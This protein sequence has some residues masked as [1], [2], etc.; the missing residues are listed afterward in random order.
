VVN[1]YKFRIFSALLIFYFTGIKIS[2]AGNIQDRISFKT[3]YSFSI[4][5]A[6][7][8]PFSETRRWYDRSI[9]SVFFNLQYAQPIKKGE[10]SIGLQ[11]V[12]KGFKTSFKSLPDP[13]F[14]YELAYQYRLYYVEM[15]V[16]YVYYFNKN[17]LI[18]G[19]VTSFLY[20][21]S[22]RFREIDVLKLNNKTTIY[23][24]NYASQYPYF[25]RFKQWDFGIN[26]GLSRKLTNSIDLECTLQKHLIN[27]DT[28]NHKDLAYNLC[29]LI[30]FR[31]CFLSSK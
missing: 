21:D 1:C 13:I 23:E 24:S 8:S 11:I 17:S 22:Y 20:D 25:D 6:G 14:E 7:Q 27:V 9:N 26:I 12:E 31:Y 5:Q 19:I 16:N 2:S 30:G 10:L 15:P 4:T 29:V 3:G 18:L 28:W